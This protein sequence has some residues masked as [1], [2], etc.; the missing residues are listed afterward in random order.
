MH[1]LEIY[2]T[3]WQIFLRQFRRGGREVEYDNQKDSNKYHHSRQKRTKHNYR[4]CSQIR[5]FLFFFLDIESEK[6]LYLY[7][8]KLE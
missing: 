6:A 5:I 8:E 2:K 3:N 7:G 4:K 1:I